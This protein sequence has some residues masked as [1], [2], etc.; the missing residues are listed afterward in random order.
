MQA[1]SLTT[2]GA[3]PHGAA[4]RRLTGSAAVRYAAGTKEQWKQ[5]LQWGGVTWLAW[6]A[7]RTGVAALHGWPLMVA[8]VWLAAFTLAWTRWSRAAIAVAILAQAIAGTG[9]AMTYAGAMHIPWALTFWLPM[10]L[11]LV[12]LL[13]MKAERPRLTVALALVS[14]WK[15]ALGSLAGWRWIAVAAGVVA[16]NRAGWAALSWTVSSVDGAQRLALWPFVAGCAPG[17]LLFGLA[18]LPRPMLQATARHSP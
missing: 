11:P 18:A 3:A 8:I 5:G 14:R 7:F 6:V 4:R 2:C 15:D 16:L 1:W 9:E 13:I 12:P 10:S 17:A